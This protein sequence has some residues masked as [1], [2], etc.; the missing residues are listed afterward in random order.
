MKTLS[1]NHL[2]KFAVKTQ[3][4]RYKVLIS[5]NDGIGITDIYVRKDVLPVPFPDVVVVTIETLED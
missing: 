5:E 1:K 2:T 4:V 3:T